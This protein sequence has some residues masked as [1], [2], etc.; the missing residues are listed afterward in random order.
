M[1][2]KV[3]SIIVITLIAVFC[4]T[5]CGESNTVEKCV[6]SN[7]SYSTTDTIKDALQ[8]ENLTAEEIAYASVDFIESPKGMEYTIKWY[9][10]GQEIKSETKATQEDK[11]D[12]IVY[13][14]DADVAAAG[15]LE[16]EII[17]NDV[18]L[19]SEQV[20]IQ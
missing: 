13:E 16:V 14:L 18:V 9:L 4:L 3:S 15:T 5:G 8:P 7:N 12:V 17:Y 20:E 19:Y 10:N 11:R 6:V 2:K 1:M